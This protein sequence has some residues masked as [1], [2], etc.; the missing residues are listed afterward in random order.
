MLSNKERRAICKRLPPLI[1]DTPIS[2]MTAAHG[3]TCLHKS[4]Y[5]KFFQYL[6]CNVWNRANQ[7]HRYPSHFPPGVQPNTAALA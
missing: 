2:D 5:P 1:T 6:A 4:F 7:V 3:H